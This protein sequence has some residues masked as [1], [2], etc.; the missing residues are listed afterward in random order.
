MQEYHYDKEGLKYLK[1]LG[2]LKKEQLESF[3]D[4]NNKAFAEGAIPPKYKELIAIAAAHITRCPYCIE[5]H[6]RRA[7]E[8]GATD[9]EIAEAIFVAVAMNAGASIAHASIAMKVLA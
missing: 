4:F 9:E 5:G 1:T 8:N 3:S 7:K 2:N 6:T